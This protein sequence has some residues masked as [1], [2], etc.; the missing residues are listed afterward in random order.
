MPESYLQ[1]PE[2]LDELA[3]QVVGQY[4]K[5]ARYEDAMRVI[6]M[7]QRS[8]RDPEDG[9]K[10]PTPEQWYQRA[11]ATLNQRSNPQQNPIDSLLR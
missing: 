1:S 7:R 6:R 3:A 8:G 4:I 9:D 5:E 10:Y 11:S 2:E